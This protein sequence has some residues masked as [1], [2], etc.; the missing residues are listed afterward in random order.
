MDET[1]LNLRVLVV[2]ADPSEADFALRVL[3]DAG[4]EGVMC[5]EVPEALVRLSREHFDAVLLAISLPRGDGLALVH[6]VR[7]LHPKVDVLV[8]ISPSELEE[9]SHA[10]ALGVLATVMRPLSGDGI[11]VALDRVRERVALARQRAKIAAQEASNHRRSMT[12]SRCADFISEI[13]GRVVIERILQ[14]AATEVRADQAAVYAPDYMGDDVFRRAAAFGEDQNAL[15]E[16]IKEAELDLDSA[17]ERSTD[18]VRV[19]LRGEGMLLGVVELR[20]EGDRPITREERDALEVVAILGGAALAATSKADAL[21]R[22]GLKDPDTS[23]YTFAFFGDAA[24]R[25][26]NRAQS[27]GRKFSMLTL[28]VGVLESMRTK[29]SAGELV[30]MRRAVVDATLGALRDSDVLARVEDDEFFILL[31]ETGLLGALACRRRIF[32]C[33]TSASALQGMSAAHIDA[34]VGIAVFPTDGGDLGRLLRA[35]RRRA[36]ASKV[37]VERR[38]SLSST[39]FWDAVEE[40][41]GV[42]DGDGLASSVGDDVID[43]HAFTELAGHATMSPELMARVGASLAADA[44]SH[45][46]AGSL[47]VAGDDALALAVARA[48]DAADTGLLRVWALGPDV[49]TNPLSRRIHLNVDEPRLRRH[50]LLMSLTESGGFAFLGRRTAD[51]QIEVYHAS[52]LD[53]VDALVTGLQNEYHLQPEVR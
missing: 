15:S 39:P 17:I 25:E 30:E 32:S 22:T 35:A 29:L 20:I 23:A 2:P 10:M 47:Y 7:A 28:S 1:R 52:D 43:S 37:G 3:D 8:M 46:L 48:L 34:N 42:S 11:M 6:H 4:D 18:K 21:A 51:N 26:I 19:L 12:H 36:D 53:V 38:L 9:S 31:P 33:L 44:L 24:G 14:V 13:D 5:A 16:L 50:V 41:L 45:R 40:L 27:H 49:P